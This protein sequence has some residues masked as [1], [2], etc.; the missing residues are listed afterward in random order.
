MKRKNKFYLLIALPA[1]LI[2][3]IMFVFPFFAVARE[4]LKGTETIKSVFL[5]PYT[6]RLLSFTAGEALLSA[7]IS[8][9]LALPV[10]VFFSTFS[11][12]GRKAVLS[13]SLSAFVMPSII[14]VLAFVIWY[15]NNGLLS[16]FLTKL[17]S[18]KVTIKILYSYSSIILAHVYLNFPLAFSVLTTALMESGT[19]EENA[20]LL[21]GKS[22]SYVFRTITI[23]KIRGSLIQ[24]FLLIFLF[25]FPSFLIVMT[26]GGNPRY[27]T[28]EAE[29]YRRAYMDGDTSNASALALFSFLIMSLLLLLSSKLKK[30]K[31]ICKNKK[32]LIPAKG[33][34]KLIAC[35]LSLI[36]L[37]FMLPPLL[38]ILYR[39]FF[40]K[41]GTFSLLTWK[42]MI[43]SPV[44]KTAIVESCLIALISSFIAV[45]MA[46]ALT[47]SQ[48][49][50][51]SRFIAILSS[52]PIALGS[53]TL[54]LGF[55]FLSSSLNLRS[56]VWR[57][58]ITVLAHTLVCLPFASRT[59]SQGAGNISEN[60]YNS[61]ITLNK[62]ILS[63]YRRVERPLLRRYVL[64]AWA[65]SFVLSLGETNATLSLG[66]GKISTL[67]VL[68]YKMINQ[69]NYQG[70]SVLSVIMIVISF[71]VFAA[72]EYLGEKK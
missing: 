54:G 41:D 4:S 8:I 13:L 17:T 2:T 16:S 61:A 60:L 53:V 71:V 38:S 28:I 69:Y 26:L 18:G 6:Y 51:R 14:V 32:V 45:R 43:L 36:I 47:I 58:I 50:R 19:T 25:C 1:L 65:L 72:S 11:F 62:S 29:I 3:L 55:S 64:R 39:S 31:K 21:L 37:S 56:E 46:S 48:L 44:V 42:N 59:V 30:E 15:G 24:T 27:Y 52:L 12:C 10:A 68:I 33:K 57:F 63:C 49:R 40:N 35:I 5:S 70:A 20:A 66:N 7:L 9:L 23:K 22:R 67:A 34:M